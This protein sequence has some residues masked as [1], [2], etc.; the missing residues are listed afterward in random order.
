[1]AGPPT[2]KALAPA[3]REKRVATAEARMVGWFGFADRKFFCEMRKWSWSGGVKDLSKQGEK[4]SDGD[5][6]YLLNPPS[7]P[8]NPNPV[9]PMKQGKNIVETGV[10]ITL[11]F[12]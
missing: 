11:R 7:I 9:R 6:W 8:V 3:A 5:G 2:V 1:M 12:Y 4:R 10:P